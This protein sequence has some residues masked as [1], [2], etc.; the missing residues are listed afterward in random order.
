MAIDLYQ[1]VTDQILAMLDKGTAPWQY[2]IKGGLPK[3]IVTQKDYRGVNVFLL[4]ITSWAKGY[5]SN[6]WLTF[7]Q[8]KEQG[9]H[10]KKGEKSTLVIFW[11]Q[12]TA[13][14]KQT[15]KDKLI[16]IIKHYNVFNQEQCENIKPQIAQQS[17]AFTPIQK[18]QDIADNYPNP[19]QVSHGGHSAFYSPQ[20]DSICIANPQ[21]FVDPESYYTTL[22]HEL[23]HST[24]H[25]SRLDRKLDAPTNTF[26]SKD[27]SKEEL[28]AEMSA[29]FL[30]ASADISTQTIDQSAAYINGWKNKIRADN[31]L[32]IQAAGAAQKAAD[33]I[34]NR[35][36]DNE[37]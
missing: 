31:K 30:A 13:Q 4:A 36:F 12:I 5:Q 29:A 37:P 21:D 7:K 9:G 3:N 18:A 2:P 11:K 33:L 16:P 6:Q 1:R 34:L 32:V 26:G 28:I 24:G 22:F 35:S 15:G 25:K 20:R 23:A 8:A 19:P 14:D 10:I 27:Y 17:S